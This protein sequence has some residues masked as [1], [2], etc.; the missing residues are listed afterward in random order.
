MRHVFIFIPGIDTWPGS[1]RN[2]DGRAV[3]WIHTHS[4]DQAEKVEYFC[5]PIGRA[6]G[7]KDRENK[8]RRTLN[9]YR[10]RDITLVGHS[11]GA[12]V[13]LQ[14]MAA[15]TNWPRIQ[16]LHLVCGACEADFNINGL[17]QLMT[18]GK[19]QSVFVYVAEADLALRL[20]HSWPAKMLGYGV[21]GLHG[22]QNVLDSVKRDVGLLSW[23]HFGHSDCWQ[24]RNFD[25]TMQH[26]IR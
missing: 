19:V 12:A 6:F 1:S 16:N 8:L 25:R 22:P 14:M 2:W 9:F 10:G 7:Q 13:I 26:F 5:G 4:E 21:M 18:Q 15:N 20:A 24:D 3:T 23:P 17:N 11:N